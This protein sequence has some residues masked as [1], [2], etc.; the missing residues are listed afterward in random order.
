M[1]SSRELYRTRTLLERTLQI[2]YPP[3][4]GEL[5]LRTELDWNKNVEPVSV[6]PE[7]VS[8]FKLA[9]RHPFLYFKPCLIQNDHFHW[10]QGDNQFLIMTEDDRR[11]SIRIS[12]VR[13]AVSFRLLSPLILPF[14]DA[15]I[16]CAF[17]HHRDTTKTPW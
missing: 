10:A 13:I 8:T 7:G 14:S 17:T 9:A 1:G 4:S 3:G 5:V 6:T 11:V 2:A 12:L 16:A 15:N